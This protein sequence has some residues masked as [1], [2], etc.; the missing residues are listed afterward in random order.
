M[1][2]FNGERMKQL[3]GERTQTSLAAALQAQ[4]FGTTQTQVSR[5]ESGQRPRGY[6]LEALAAELAVA[7]DDLFEEVDDSESPFRAAA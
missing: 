6:I 4:G 5:W 2:K 3:R 7:V 1:K